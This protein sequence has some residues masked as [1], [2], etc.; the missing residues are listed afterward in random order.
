MS[1]IRINRSLIVLQGFA[2]AGALALLAGVDA[3]G[4]DKK[5]APP[6]WTVAKVEFKG[7]DRIADPI[8]PPKGAK[9]APQKNNR[10]FE[11][12][13]D[14]GKVVE[15]VKETPYI[16]VTHAA[17][18]KLDPNE[19][20]IVDALGQEH[21]APSQYYVGRNNSGVMVFKRA[22]WKEF[23]ELFLKG[24]DDQQVPLS[25]FLPPEEAAAWKLKTATIIADGN[26]KDKAKEIYQLIIKQYPRT[27]A[28][29]EAQQLLAKMK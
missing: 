27:K 7:P 29:K 18:F 14:G 21:A 25:K 16:T 19:F 4:A 12:G 22:N 15:G 28:A 17:N 8:P 11:F 24:P 5:N 20:K 13:K 23:G 3:L 1:M 2:L 26:D 10:E 9:V 6:Q